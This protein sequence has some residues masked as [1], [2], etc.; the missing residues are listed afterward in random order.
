MT[1]TATLRGTP[2]QPEVDQRLA[3]AETA[4]NTNDT[5]A[6]ARVA[7]L[8]NGLFLPAAAA[9][10]ETSTTN[11]GALSVTKMQSLIHSAGSETRTLAAP[12]A[13]GRFK[14]IRMLTD[15]GDVTLAMT[16]FHA[17]LGTASVITFGDVGDSLVLVSVASKWLVI[18]YPGCG[19]T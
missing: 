4:V 5:A 3:D 12:A 10:T 7:S 6:L 15:G 1:L 19:A 9:N 18:G 14:L 16:N 13:D 11:A 17:T 8:E 2:F